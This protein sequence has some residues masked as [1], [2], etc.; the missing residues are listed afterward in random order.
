MFVQ[1]SLIALQNA[2]HATVI[3]L[4]VGDAAGREAAAGRVVVA[5]LN[6]TPTLES[7]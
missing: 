4:Q 7:H 2:C 1:I 5:D 6:Q 3:R